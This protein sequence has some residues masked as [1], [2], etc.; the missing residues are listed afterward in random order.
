MT[1]KSETPSL[2][3]PLAIYRVIEKSLCGTKKQTYFY[4]KNTHRISRSK[5]CW[6]FIISVWNELLYILNT[7]E[8]FSLC[9]KKSTEALPE[10]SNY[11][12]GSFW[13]LHISRWPS[14]ADP[15][16]SLPKISQF[17]KSYFTSMLQHTYVLLAYTDSLT[18]LHTTSRHHCQSS[19]LCHSGLHVSIILV[20]ISFLSQNVPKILQVFNANTVTTIL[21][22][23]SFKNFDDIR[24][25]V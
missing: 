6:L 12:T 10:R 23:N 18:L 16:Y 8:L 22:K 9:Y 15:Y 14:K 20:I 4:F 5:Y 13:S 17:Q 11:C 1:Q 24:N 2:S 3:Q 7:F 21:T 19:Q 25:Y